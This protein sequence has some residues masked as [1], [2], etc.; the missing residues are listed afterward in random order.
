MA[1][2]LFFDVL[3]KHQE[4]SNS[5]EIKPR[6]ALRISFYHTEHIDFIAKAF[7]PVSGQLQR[8]NN[9]LISICENHDE[10]M[11]ICREL[12]EMIH[13]FNDA[14]LSRPFH[15]NWLA[16]YYEVQSFGINYISAEKGVTSIEDE[17]KRQ[18]DKE[19]AKDDPEQYI[20]RRAH[21]KAHILGYTLEALQDDVTDFFMACANVKESNKAHVSSLIDAMFSELKRCASGKMALE[22]YANQRLT[23][24]VS[25]KSSWMSDAQELQPQ[26]RVE[27]YRASIEKMDNAERFRQKN[28]IT[29]ENVMAAINPLVN[30]LV[31][32]IELSDMPA[33]FTGLDLMYASPYELSDLSK[34]RLESLAKSRYCATGQMAAY[35]LT[36]LFLEYFRMTSRARH[37]AALTAL[38]RT[39]SPDNLYS[40]AIEGVYRNMVF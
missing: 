37:K 22:N 30:A 25:S 20:P 31:D 34:S 28:N 18:S 40:D 32:E 17:I 33:A 21:A 10:A 27:R 9:V 29:F 2:R 12:N 24:A 8:A 3:K 19:S 7:E 11:R 16:E 15:P 23:H 26:E 13:S 5:V 38:S 14:T 36:D 6:C 1:Q 4:R 39:L 35:I